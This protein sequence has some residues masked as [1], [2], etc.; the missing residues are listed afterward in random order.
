MVAESNI[1][2]LGYLVEHLQATPARICAAADSVGVR[3]ALT[4]NGSKL[5]FDEIDVPRIRAALARS[6]A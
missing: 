6:K 3:P 4:I 2:T 5:Y 1:L